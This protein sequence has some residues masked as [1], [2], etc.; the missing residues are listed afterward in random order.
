MVTE[1]VTR[2]SYVRISSR[3]Y[4]QITKELVVHIQLTAVIA[5][6]IL[7]MIKRARLQLVLPFLT[8]LES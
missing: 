3:E 1:L 4:A 8:I 5:L 6:N 2:V 7:A